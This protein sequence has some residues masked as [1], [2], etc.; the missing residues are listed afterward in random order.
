MGRSILGLTLEDNDIK[1]ILLQARVKGFD[2]IQC[3]HIRIGEKA[4]SEVVNELN[5]QVRIRPDSVYLTIN[6]SGISFRVV[7]LPFKDTKGISKALPFELEATLPFP[8]DEKVIDFCYYWNES[9]AHVITCLLPRET[10]RIWLEELKKVNLEPEVVDVSI[11][12]ISNYILKQN[13]HNN[14]FILHLSDN[15]ASIS[16]IEANRIAF[17]RQINGSIR[18]NTNDQRDLLK[19]VN[20]VKMTLT[21][22]KSSFSPSYA[23]TQGYVFGNN[24]YD[25]S[26]LGFFEEN[27]GIPV[28]SRDILSS[29]LAD[30]PK[31]VIPELDTSLVFPTALLGIELRPAFDLR[32]EAFPRETKLPSLLRYTRLTLIL[33]ALLLILWGA[34]EFVNV[35]IMETRFQKLQTQLIS[36]YASTF[37]ETKP[38]QDPVASA[39][40]QLK[41]FRKR[42]KD[43][44]LKVSSIKTIDILHDIIQNIPDNIKVE[45]DRVFVDSE[46]IQIVGQSD[47]YNSIDILKNEFQSI[48]YISESNIQS[49]KADKTGKN[50]N[51]EIRLKRKG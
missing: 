25:F 49:A 20:E 23:P 51:F 27:L 13:E 42:F 35:N 9:S 22:Y 33:L 24:S 39:K 34:R 18:L 37:N 4:A 43:V 8:L 44:D 12:P 30:F 19:F 16:I 6:T 41:E 46:A 21:S 26:L 48:P 7:R 3:F 5:Q 2:V 1:A 28:S 40:A 29:Y 38:G 14:F 15:V 10:I 31:P 47:S 45:L 11:G 36:I 32:K 50:I 17:M